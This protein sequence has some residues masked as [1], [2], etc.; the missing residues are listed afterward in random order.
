[1]PDNQ[2]FVRLKGQFQWY[3]WAR[4]VQEN[5]IMNSENQAFYN[6][7][8]SDV[9]AYDFSDLAFVSPKFVNTRIDSIKSEIG[10]NVLTPRFA[11]GDARITYNKGVVGLRGYGQSSANYFESSSPLLP[12]LKSTLAFS[13]C[14]T[15]TDHQCGLV[16]Q[17]ASGMDGRLQINANGQYNGSTI[18]YSPNKLQVFLEGAQDGSGING[19]LVSCDFDVNKWYTLV[20][21][22][23]DQP[24]ESKYYING[25]LVDSFTATAIANV[26]TQVLGFSSARSTSN[27]ALNKI[28]SI[29]ETITDQQVLEVHDFLGKPF[30]NKSCNDNDYLTSLP[31]VSSQSAS[32]AIVPQDGIFNEN[33]LL[34][35]QNPEH[36]GLQASM[37]KV[38]TSI[39]LLD[40]E[41]NLDTI[42]ERTSND[43]ASGSGANL[44]I[45]DKILI[46]STLRNMMLPS[47]NVT[48]N[49]I[50][51]IYGEKLLISDG[52]TDFTS[53]DAISRW[54]LE[55]NKKAQEIKM[56]DTIFATPSGLDTA[57]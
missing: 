53:S 33:L 45:G 43:S 23:S 48:A 50:G 4:L 44:S 26:N 17:H 46:Y 12:N 5:E 2:V 11:S 24:N 56:L 6:L 13:F 38:I 29:S 10:N 22:L 37:T 40:I 9:I 32:A 47:S 15:T 20:L 34:Y 27:A 16:W 36:I 49:I 8:G 30:N 35:S 3:D 19:N 28:I 39:V 1:M 21:V 7:F 52:V 41:S 31:L 18:F 55:I 42:I 14:V 57:T 51:R 25:K 54:V